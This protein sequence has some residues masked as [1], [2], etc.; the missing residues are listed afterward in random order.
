MAIVR[1]PGTVVDF[2]L[3]SDEGA[4]EEDQTHIGIRVPSEADRHEVKAIIAR[5]ERNPSESASGMR[6]ILGIAVDYVRNLKFEDG[7]AFELERDQ[8]GAITRE[9]ANVLLEFSEE[10][11]TLYNRVTRVSEAERKNF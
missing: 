9:S 7:E 8:K 10:V 4:P 2:V 3:P 1:R 6:R 5:V 11:M